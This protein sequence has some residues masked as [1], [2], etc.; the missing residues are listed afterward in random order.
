MAHISSDAT[1]MLPP[2]L[3]P[4]LEREI[5]EMAAHIRPIGILRLMLVAS[6]V[7]I[8]LEPLLYRTIAL[9]VH[10]FRASSDHPNPQ[11][12]SFMHV[13]QSNPVAFLLASVRHLYLADSVP[14]EHAKWLLSTCSGIEN[15][16]IQ[17]IKR[18]D[19]LPSIAHLP[20][21]G[22]NAI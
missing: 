7:K 17:G 21:N 13:V 16:S 12:K 18:S 1:N 11:W 9:S 19:L 14:S 20:L 10:P 4:E 8:W 5:F 15:L 6:R 3:P 22:F 2:L